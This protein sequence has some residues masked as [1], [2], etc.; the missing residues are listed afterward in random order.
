L[1]EDRFLLHV[2][3]RKNWRLRNKEHPL[4]PGWEIGQYSICHENVRANI[5]LGARI[6]DIVVKDRKAVIRSAFAV[7]GSEG[8][9]SSRILYFTHYYFADREPIELP[10]PYIQYRQMKMSTY[11]RKY[12]SESLWDKVAKRYAKYRKGQKPVSIDEDSGRGMVTFASQKRQERSSK[13]S[14]YRIDYKQCQ[15]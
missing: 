9:G 14:P 2:S 13:Y 1:V 15:S 5:E 4:D 12:G 8:R 10:E 11:I 6:F 7:S 3:D